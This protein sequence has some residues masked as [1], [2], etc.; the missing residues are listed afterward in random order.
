MVQAE[1]KRSKAIILYGAILC[2]AIGL[3][4][5]SL[6]FVRPVNCQ[7][8]CGD[9]DPTPCPSGACRFGEQRAGLPMPVLVDAPGGGSP[10]NGW[11]ILGPEDLP[12][13][14]TFVFDVLF[15]GVFLWLVRHITRV[16]RGKEPSV[17]ILAAALSAAVV[18][19]GLVLGGLAY[20]P[21]LA[22]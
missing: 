4:V 19:T 16:V 14:L 11:G 2:L 20:W 3:T 17:N 21:F 8:L 13:P 18:L 9:L 15:Y 10:T 7:R 6:A 1:M 5:A 22:R 12:N